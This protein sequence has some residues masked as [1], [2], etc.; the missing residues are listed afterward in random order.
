MR[1]AVN[2]SPAHDVGRC[3]RPGLASNFPAALEQHQGGNAANLI[4]GAELGFSFGINFRQPQLRLQLQGSGS[5][6]WSHH[7]A[8][9][10]P[11]GPKIHQ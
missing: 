11:G 5:E 10:A 6:G 4:A 9:A 1:L 2:P 8:R 7:F 3:H